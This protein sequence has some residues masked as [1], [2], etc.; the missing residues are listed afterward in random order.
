MYAIEI[1]VQGTVATDVDRRIT[2]S[3]KPMSRFRLAAN[4]R[5]QDR[6]SGEW[7]DLPTT[8]LNVTCWGRL[9]EHVS[10]CL[11]KGTPVVVQGRLRER[12]YDRE[13]SGVTV[14]GSSLDLNARV[15][16][17]DLT[18]GVAE[19]KRTKS[20]AVR[21]AEERALAETGLGLSAA[22]TIAT[23]SFV[24]DAEPPF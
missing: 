8:W 11:A 21:Q 12:R 4:E 13:I 15:I 14:P 20:P 22:G 23:S 7:K 17:P 10:Q 1:T 16:G 5:V 9:A 19:F 2:E 3:G 24:A 6:V 18:K